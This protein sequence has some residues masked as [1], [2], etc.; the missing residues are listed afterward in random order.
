MLSIPII[1]GTGTE[2]LGQVQALLS[3]GH[4]IS[5]PTDSACHTTNPRPIPIAIRLNEKKDLF[6]DSDDLG[7]TLAKIDDV[8][9]KDLL[10]SKIEE[11]SSDFYINYLINLTTVIIN[12]HKYLSTLEGVDEKEST[13]FE[14]AYMSY[15]QK[16]DLSYMQKAIDLTRAVELALCGAKITKLLRNI[17]RTNGNHSKGYRQELQAGWF[18]AK[19]SELKLPCYFEHSVTLPT[20]RRDKKKNDHGDWIIRE[21]D[22]LTDNDIVS[23]KSG[24]KQYSEQVRN[25]FFT[26]LDDRNLDLKEKIKRIILIKHAERPEQLSLNYLCS[27]EYREFLDTLVEEARI[28]IK[29]YSSLDSAGEKLLNKL[30][31]KHSIDV[32]FTP[33]VNGSRNDQAAIDN[34]KTVSQWIQDIYSYLDSKTGEKV[35]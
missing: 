7:I 3:N 33:T 34:W 19:I 23:V 11:P 2:R 24:Q 16:T 6:C 25:L 18:E 28:S 35:A 14:K 10:F 29:E 8:W 32:Y 13:S 27:D 22:I 20:I 4:I 26:I 30:I 1:N 15:L 9:R 21:I 5:T 31:T 17:N 12:N